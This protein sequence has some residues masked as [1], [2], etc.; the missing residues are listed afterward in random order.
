VSGITGRIVH[1]IA[2]SKGDSLLRFRVIGMVLTT[3][4]LT[5]AGV[6]LLVLAWS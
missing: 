5:A 4:A 1:A 6:A 2:V 3:F